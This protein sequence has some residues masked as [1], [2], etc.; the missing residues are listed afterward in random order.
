MSPDQLHESICFCFAALLNKSRHQ[1]EILN[2]V[3]YLS[4]LMNIHKVFAAQLIANSFTAGVWF[5]FEM[6]D[7]D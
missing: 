4:R 7:S 3:L 2:D 6:N 1:I 5:R